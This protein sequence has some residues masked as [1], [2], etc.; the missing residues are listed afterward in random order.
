MSRQIALLQTA[1]R[2]VSFGGFT[3]CLASAV[4]THSRF[5]GTRGAIKIFKAASTVMCARP[6]EVLRLGLD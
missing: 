2:R 1:H 4:R 6:N 5:D 3:F